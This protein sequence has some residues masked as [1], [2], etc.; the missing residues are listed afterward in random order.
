MPPRRGSSRRPDPPPDGLE[1]FA[2][3][4][5]GEDL[6]VAVTVPVAQHLDLLG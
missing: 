1:N 4:A 2:A 6:A 5:A 3:G